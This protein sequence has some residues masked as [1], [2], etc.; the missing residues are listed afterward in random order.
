MTNKNPKQTSTSTSKI[1]E[2]FEPLK[3]L[4]LQD[5]KDLSYRRRNFIDA[6]ITHA[7]LKSR[8]IL[9]GSNKKERTDKG[10]AEL[11]PIR[12]YLC[13][14][15]LLEGGTDEEA[16][17]EAVFDVL[18]KVMD[19]NPFGKYMRDDQVWFVLYSLLAYETFLCIIA[20]LL[21]S[22]SYKTLH[23]IYNSHYFMSNNNGTNTKMF[24]G[25]MCNDLPEELKFT[26][27]TRIELVKG[28]TDKEG[29]Q[30]EDIQQA[31]LLSSFISCIKPVPTWYPGTLHLPGTCITNYPLFVHAARHKN[32]LN[33]AT[34]AGANSPDELEKASAGKLKEKIDKEKLKELNISVH[35]DSRNFEELVNM[36]AWD[37]VE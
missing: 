36:A 33:L 27:A 34:I 12:D 5:T 15:I 21:K 30:F 11:K 1:N 2:T 24:D 23:K 3:E 28:R 9:T 20:S 26:L 35:C 32:F 16:F 8:K 22:K 18:E 10:L 37:A 13:E 6:C 14:W 17:S 29:I 7:D 31:D 19:L 25:F 4:I